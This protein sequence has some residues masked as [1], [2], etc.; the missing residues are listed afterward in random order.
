MA[1]QID[2]SATIYFGSSQGLGKYRENVRQGFKDSPYH[3]KQFGVINTPEVPPTPH[4]KNQEFLQ[5]M[6]EHAIPHEQLPEQLKKFL[7]NVQPYFDNV[8]KSEGLI[9]E[10]ESLDLRIHYIPSKYWQHKVKGADFDSEGY[11]DLISN[12]VYISVPNWEPQNILETALN[13]IHELRHRVTKRALI[14]DLSY[15]KSENIIRPKGVA[16]TTPLGRFIP[17]QNSFSF[18]EEMYTEGWTADH[19][20]EILP[21]ALQEEYQKRVQHLTKIGISGSPGLATCLIV[22]RQGK[23]TNEMSNFHVNVLALSSGANS[24]IFFLLI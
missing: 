7:G 9:N 11:F 6:E 3:G 10:N 19:V 4:Q 22:D 18:L 21:P 15:D 24:K 16:V 1:E 17:N 8:A 5:Y 13:T 2:T 14:I 20:T 23:L 12:S